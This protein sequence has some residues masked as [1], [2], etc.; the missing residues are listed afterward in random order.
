MWVSCQICLLMLLMCTQSWAYTTADP[1]V[2]LNELPVKGVLLDKGWKYM[3]GD[4]PEWAKPSYNDQHWSSID[5]SQDIHDIPALWQ[6]HTGWFRL[7][8]SLD[9][10]LRQESLALL[11]QQTGASEIYLNGRL[12]GKYGKI[13]DGPEEVQAAIPPFG[14]FI[15]L[16]PQGETQLVLAVRFALQKNIPYVLYVGSPNRA[17]ALRVMEIAGV[18]QLVRN[19][20]YFLDYIKSSIFF[21]MCL[22]HLVLFWFSPNRKANLYFF[23]FSAM[24]MVN[25]FLHAVTSKYVFL[26]APKM[27]L[28][29]FFSLLYISS[30]YFFL[31]AIYSVLRQPRGLIF[32]ALT[33]AFFLSIPLFLLS[34]R[35]GWL[36]SMVLY[37]FL[38]FLESARIALLAQR[39]KIRGARIVTYGAIGFLVFSPLY[40]FIVWDILPSGPNDI[41]LH[42]SFNLGILSLPI[43]IS[44]YLATEAS[45]TSRS[46]QAKQVEVQQL[47]EK[48]LEQEREKQHLQELDELKSRFFANISH[49]FRTPLSLIR[50]TVEKLKKKETTA[51]ERQADYQVIDRNAGRLLQMISQLLDLS[52]LEAGKLEL[53][54]Q[55]KDI[56][57]LLKVL[58]GSFASL[59][60]SKDITYRYTVPLQPIWVQLDSEKLSQIINNLLSNAVK[61]TPP[62]G[63]V[64]FSATAQITNDQSCLLRIQVQDT[65]I[66]IS[67]AQLPHI[68]DRFYQADNSVTRRHEGTG[69]GMALVRELV[70]LHGGEIRVES[71]EGKGS[72]FTVHISFAM[73]AAGEAALGE[74]QEAKLETIPAV[75]AM[76][77]SAQQAAK[78]SG[79]KIHSRGHILVVE[80][81]ADLRHFIARY[82]ADNYVVTEASN[83]IAGYRQAVET[84][85]DL[86]ISDVMMPELDGVS[87]CQKLKEDERTSHIPVVLLTAKADAESKLRGL[88]MGADDYL[89]KPFSAEELV[90]RVDNLIGQRQKLREKFSRSLTLQPSDV[91]VTSADE[92]F[93][94]KALSVVEENISNP[95]FH[96]D[97]F[98][99]AI[100]MSRAQLNRKLTALVDQS[101]NEFIRTIRLKRAASLLRQHGG[102]VG[103]VAFMV[104]FSSPNYFTKCFRDYYGVAPSDYLLSGTAPK[105]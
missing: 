36:L 50:G 102:N 60:E 63:E 4:N 93:L 19:E 6:H 98:S 24:S 28:L 71:T 11:I 44:I 22:L 94:Q 81:N 5:P 40:R 42:L 82:L 58:G 96:V 39:K 43:S 18:T 67:P 47:S 90:L 16:Q 14:E 74:E 59:F 101:P 41:F 95:D 46:L 26:A 23:I 20:V 83:G 76:A 57:R 8:I 75:D 79:R 53:H 56:S 54:P 104:G 29:I 17:L 30:A 99:R 48:A 85:P 103:E 10:A 35:T 34:Y 9:S 38:A 78:H 84:V 32:W 27:L 77:G 88:G 52:R 45:F 49:E 97:A 68:F 91:S 66:G 37:P 55:P 65:G 64:C 61:F 7:Q 80:D 12:I 72:I 1:T 21:V 69:I 51:A 105:K 15:S 31:L 3:P 87:L 13:G 2:A 86:V 73:A 100:G 33:A 92:R 89:T 62:G 70:Q 25:Y